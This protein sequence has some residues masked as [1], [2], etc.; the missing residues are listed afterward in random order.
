ME[1]GLALSIHPF[2]L[3]SLAP[4]PNQ[5]NGSETLLH[6][7]LHQHNILPSQNRDRTAVTVLAKVSGGILSGLLLAVLTV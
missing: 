3:F 7:Q 5:A 1:H 4:S 6:F 2:I